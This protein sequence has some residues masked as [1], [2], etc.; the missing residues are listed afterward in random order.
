MRRLASPRLLFLLVIAPL[1][2]AQETQIGGMIGVG[3]FW[4]YK[5]NS[6]NYVV[7]GGEACVKCGGRRGLYLEYNHWSRRGTGTGTY[8]ATSWDLAGLG[9]RIQGKGERLRPFFD[10]GLLVGSK[11]RYTPFL[12]NVPQSI[13][14]AGGGLGFGA[15]VSVSEH[16]YVR[17]FGRVFLL[18]TNEN[19]GFAGA[20][21]GYRF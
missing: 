7:A 14:A 9:L 11:R 10:I 1:I 20:S 13:Y 16:W 18:S 6:A 2:F 3:R 15:A 21:V 4:K 19:G 8:P 5:W 17:P 12:V